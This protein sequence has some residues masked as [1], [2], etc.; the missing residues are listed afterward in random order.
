MRISITA[1]ET[2][3]CEDVSAPKVSTDVRIEI[4][5]MN[6]RRLTISATLDPA[7]IARLL[8]VLDVS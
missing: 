8:P 2:A 1:P 6:R 3:P 4:T 7:I 5:L